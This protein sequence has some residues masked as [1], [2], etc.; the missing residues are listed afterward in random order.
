MNLIGTAYW[1]IVGERKIIGICIGYDKTR[2]IRN[3]RYQFTYSSWEYN[4]SNYLALK[5]F[6][7]CKKLTKTEI[8]LYV[9][10]EKSD[11]C[12]R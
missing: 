8:T 11:L 9:P 6:K 7:K 4:G 1:F 12:R 2:L 3:G 5:R 10:H